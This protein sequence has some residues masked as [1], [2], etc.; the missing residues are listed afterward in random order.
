MNSQLLTLK[1]KK[2]GVK[3]ASIRQKT[4]FS[5]SEVE[6]KTG[7]LSDVLSRMEQGVEIPSLPQL[8]TLASLFEVPVEKLTTESAVE[9]NYLSLDHNIQR[10][11]EGL[12][13]RVIGMYLKQNRLKKNLSIEQV[14]QNCDLTSEQIEQYETGQAPVPFLVLEDLCA[15][16]DISAYSFQDTAKVTEKAD[17]VIAFSEKIATSTN[18]PE[19]L[20]DFVSKPINQPFIALAKRLSSL[21]AT[22]LRKIA[23]SLLEIT[24]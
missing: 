14:A 18:L 24:L 12:R 23:E 10:Q 2:L 7:I 13:N 5:V 22:E 21:N 8:E 4:G 6:V 3:I 16:L 19:E 1:A 20:L 9:K 17:N 11:L 15:F